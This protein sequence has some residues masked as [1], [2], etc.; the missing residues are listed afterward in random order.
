MKVNMSQIKRAHSEIQDILRLVPFHGT[1]NKYFS[2]WSFALC[3]SGKGGEEF[4][5][6]LE[7]T[8]NC[9][10][11]IPDDAAAFFRARLQPV[12]VRASPITL[13]GGCPLISRDFYSGEHAAA[14]YIILGTNSTQRAASITM[15][16]VKRR[17]KTLKE[18][19]RTR[20]TLFVHCANARR[21]C[22]RVRAL[23]S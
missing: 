7:L 10:R 3:E 1:L 6:I 20:S 18:S 5:W 17:V 23:S 4:C 15:P 13:F 8:V 16:E 19:T 9:F 21:T 22:P 2:Q 14:R 12:L 11:L